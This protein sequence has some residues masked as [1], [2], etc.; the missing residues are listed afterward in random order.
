MM[1]SVILG[2]RQQLCGHSD[3][4]EHKRKANRTFELRTYRNEGN[5]KFHSDD[6]LVISFF[7]LHQPALG[8]SP[9]FGIT[10]SPSNEC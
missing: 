10:A 6:P 7:S 8:D 2:G 1:T 3:H 5:R 4:K 9:F